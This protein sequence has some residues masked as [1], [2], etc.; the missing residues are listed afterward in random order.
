MQHV[1]THIDRALQKQKV[2]LVLYTGNF[3][4]TKFDYF[5]RPTDESTSQSGNRERREIYI[6][7]TSAEVHPKGWGPTWKCL[8]NITQ[9]W[10]NHKTAKLWQSSQLVLF[11]KTTFRI[12]LRLMSFIALEFVFSVTFYFSWLSLVQVDSCSGLFSI[13]LCTKVHGVEITVWNSII[14]FKC[15]LKT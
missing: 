15:V 1:I 7:K 13:F 9:D 5:S 2:T 12:P 8:V 3:L 10:W 14:M 4:R 11:F 6:V